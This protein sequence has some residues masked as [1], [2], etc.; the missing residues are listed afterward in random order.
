MVAARADV[1]GR[2]AVVTKGLADG[3]ARVRYEALQ[4]WGRSVAEDLVR[5]SRCRC[6]RRKSARDAAG[7]RSA[8][9]RLSRRPQ[10]R[11]ARFRRWPRR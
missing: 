2:E 5:A 7:H 9:Q 10:R 8:R 11:S 4:T 3:N 1:E 6:S